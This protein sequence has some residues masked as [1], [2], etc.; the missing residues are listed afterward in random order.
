MDS[1]VSEGLRESVQET[2]FEL[3]YFISLHIL[4]CFWFVAL[5]QAMTTH[6]G[7]IPRVKELDSDNNKGTK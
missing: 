4:M 1:L 7:T 5:Y 3:P 2:V 6:P